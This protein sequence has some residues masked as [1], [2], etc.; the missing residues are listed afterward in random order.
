MNPKELR[1]KRAKLH[2]QSV[3]LLKEGRGDNGVL[4]TEQSAQWDK[5]HAEMV[6]LNTHIQRLEDADEQTRLLDLPEPR[7]VPQAEPRT[8]EKTKEELR[9]LH[10]ARARAWG[11][12]SNGTDEQQ[13]M[14]R[15]FSP[16]NTL[17][18]KLGDSHAARRMQREYR[19]QSVGTG[20]E[21]G[22]TVEEEF[23]NELEKALLFFGGMRQVSRIMRTDTGA[24]MPWPTTN[25][26]N[27]KGRI[28]A[29]NTVE[30]TQD[31]VF[32]QQVFNAFKYTSEFVK[33]PIELLQDSAFDMPTEVGAMLGE[34]LGRIHNEHFTTGAGTTEP[35]G[36]VTGS[37][38]GVTAAT[39]AAITWEE[40][41]EL[42]VS[43]DVAY[44]DR[45]ASF[46]FN[47]TT[48]G[49]LR[50]IFDSDGRPIWQPGIEAATPNTLNGKLY[51]INNDMASIATVAKTMLFGDFSK[52]IIRDVLDITLRRLDERFA[53]LHQVAFVAIS[54][55]DGQVL[56]AGTNPI[57]HLIQAA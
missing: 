43:V 44:R 39:N 42:E 29:E 2:E 9:T 12:G 46:M 51:T 56:E 6:E 25:D 54:R 14:A 49:F 55:N 10:Y 11:L 50:R 57:K 23:V 17:R 27:N 53:D 40:I 4:D 26:T 18:L 15:E 22:F 36:A 20:S 47:D 21:G 16:S 30:T 28:L 1:E 48:F 7:I 34:R 32:G 24:P 3:A 41:I 52:Y 37:V 5:M 19:Q 38:L 35:E 45:G 8:D 13:A 33:V 31:I